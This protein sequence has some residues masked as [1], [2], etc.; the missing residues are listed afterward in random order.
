MLAMVDA[1]SDEPRLRV[2]LLHHV[3]G[4]QTGLSLL[5]VVDSWKQLEFSVLE[6][7]AGVLSELPCHGSQNES[8]L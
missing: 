2:Y 7:M 3:E 1:I 5:P 6:D 8:E 4:L